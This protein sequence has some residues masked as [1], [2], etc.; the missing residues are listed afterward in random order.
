MS[1]K[2]EIKEIWQYIKAQVLLENENKM[3]IVLTI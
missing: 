1:K 3:L 2:S